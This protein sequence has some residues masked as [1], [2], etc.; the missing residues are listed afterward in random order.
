MVSEASTE[1]PPGWVPQALPAAWRSGIG[2]VGVGAASIIAG[3]LVAAVTRPTGFE[4]GAWVAAFLVLVGGVAQ[5]LAGAGQAGLVVE[6]PSRQ[7]LAI[8]LVTWNVGCAAT[9][10]GTLLANPAVTSLGGVVLIA[11]LAV[12]LGAVLGP[13]ARPGPLRTAYVVVVAFVLISTPVGLAL[14]WLRH[15]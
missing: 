3:G 9:I 12:F 2:F 15:S 5:I 11:S 10:L 1:T 14:A 6:A 8:E 7:T 4:E 13:K